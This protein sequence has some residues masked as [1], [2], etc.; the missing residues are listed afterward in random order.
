MVGLYDS[1]MGQAGVA[2][3]IAEHQAMNVREPVRLIHEPAANELE[4]V[5]K[6]PNFHFGSYSRIVRK[7]PGFCLIHQLVSLLSSLNG[8]TFSEESKESKESK[9]TGSAN[10]FE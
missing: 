3:N 4:S 1:R 7:V 10:C 5:L 2:H 9:E 8:L 6:H